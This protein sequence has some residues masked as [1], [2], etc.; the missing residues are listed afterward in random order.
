[1][2]SSVIGRP[3][4]LCQA[5]SNIYINWWHVAGVKWWS[6]VSGKWSWDGNID[7]WTSLD[8]DQLSMF[9]ER[10]AKWRGSFQVPTGA[11]IVVEQ[12]AY[13]TGPD[14]HKHIL[15]DKRPEPGL[16]SRRG[17]VA[18]T[19]APTVHFG[20][21]LRRMCTNQTIQMTRSSRPGSKCGKQQCRAA[22]TR[23][24]RTMPPMSLLANTMTPAGLSASASLYI[25]QRPASFLVAHERRDCEFRV[26]SSP[27]GA[28]W[29]S[30]L[31]P[32]CSPPSYC[33]RP[34][35]PR[36]SAPRAPSTAA[37]AAARRGRARLMVRATS[38]AWPPPCS[39]SQRSFGPES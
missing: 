9:I 5:S 21:T 8:C 23:R 26:V 29:T 34:A 13:S 36:T 6:T 31:L 24:D 10:A 37:A 20:R 1:M 4:P 30:R 25:T 16:R 32:R 11:H 3:Q 17:A 28:G 27:A 39:L 14:E 2:F 22:A 15:K 7:H 19:E 18:S 35:S 12:A 33:S 38:W